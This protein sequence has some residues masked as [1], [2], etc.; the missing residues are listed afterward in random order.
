MEIELLKCLNDLES[1]RKYLVKKGKSRFSGNC[2]KNKLAET[3]VIFKRS[4]E[5]IQF[6]SKEQGI[7]PNILDKINSVWNNIKYVYDVILKLCSQPIK[8]STSSN[9][10]SEYSETSE[11]STSTM[12]FDLKTACNLIPVM[13]N[14]EN[15]I[16]RIIDSVDMYSDM[17]SVAGNK[18]LVKFVLKSR[19]TENAKL[20]LSSD[21]ATASDL[22][23]DIRNKLLTKKSFT[24]I[25][26]RLQ[27][28]TQGWRTIDQYGTELEKLFTDLTISQA[29]GNPNDFNVLKRLNEQTAIQRF[30]DG[31][32]DSRLSVI[33]AAKTFQHLNE[34]I[35]AAKDHE[36]SSAS[37][38][39]SRGENV[40]QFSRRG[41]RGMSHHNYYQDR[42]FSGRSRG[43]RG[44]YHQQAR[45]PVR[46]NFTASNRQTTYYANRGRGSRF[47][48]NTRS[49]YPNTHGRGN[50]NRNHRVFYSEQVTPSEP[51]TAEQSNEVQFFRA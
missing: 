29:N 1:V 39:T 18:L 8:E 30:S 10:E 35:Q 47:S 49:S 23:N 40:M 42:Q 6:L 11:N 16:K 14:T 48:R 24:A 20:R 32:R 45:N 5:V 50:N 17:L 46:P 51:Q 21:Y 25:Q 41:T 36:L 19:L 2:I 22:V 31:L 34:A 33:I 15:S 37:S 4:E 26:S 3:E 44:F 12:E 43:Q 27:S 9:S 7:E 38:S 28:I 13:D